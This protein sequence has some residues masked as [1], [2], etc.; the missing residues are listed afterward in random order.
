MAKKHK[1]Q[2][3]KDARNGMAADA[4]WAGGTG[5]GGLGAGF[6]RG[7]PGLGRLSRNE[8]FLL[9]AL[10]GAGAAWVLSDAELRGKVMKAGMKLY[11]NLVGGFE[12]MKE[13]MA[14][15][16]AELEAEQHGGA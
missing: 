13:Q 9:G 16:R 11:A 6:L 4:G 14:D 15:L 5:Q 2:R 10:I 8:Q 1:K 12:E 7:I 3:R